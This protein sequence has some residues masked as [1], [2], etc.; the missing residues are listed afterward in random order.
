MSNKNIKKLFKICIFY[1]TQ[2]GNVLILIRRLS[3]ARQN[4]SLV[5]RNFATLWPEFISKEHFALGTFVAYN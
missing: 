2:F 1:Q 4:G 3:L 5:L